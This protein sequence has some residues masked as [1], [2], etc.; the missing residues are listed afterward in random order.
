MAKAKQRY[1][2]I[3]EEFPIE[4]HKPMLR[5]ADAIMER[6]RTEFAVRRE[7]FNELRSAIAELAQAQKRT[8]ERVEELAQAQKRTEERV[9][10]LA[11]IQKRFEKHFDM[12]IG[13]LGSRWGIKTEESFRAA[14]EGI[15][16]EDFGMRV[17]RYMA[18]DEEGE[19]FG[20]PDQIEIDILIRDDKITAIEIKSSMSKSD[21]YT[22]DNK[23]SFYEKSHQVKVDRKLIITPMLDPRATELVKTLGMKVYTS[24]YDW[25]D[26]EQK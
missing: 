1:M 23:V 20:R 8:E 10:E 12:Q 24:C 3:V 11:Q 13:A 9:E 25:G 15:L 5:L 19:V 14:A 7:D 6:I 26:E 21:V 22:F 18:Y 2:E 4:L 17:E 16:G